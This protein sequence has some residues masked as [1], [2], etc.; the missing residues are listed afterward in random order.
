M[1]DGEAAPR[2]P[3]PGSESRGRTRERRRKARTVL[4]AHPSA[5]LYGSDRVLLESV[6][7]LL[8]AGWQVVATVPRPGPLVDELVAR[9]AGVEICPTPVLRKSALRPAGLVRFALEVAASV[10]PA[11]RLLART[12]AEAV[13]VNTVTVPTWML[14]GR[15][16]R[17]RVLC[18]VHEAEGSASP[19]LRRLLALPLLLAHQVLVNSTFSLDVLGSA[20][21]TLRRRATVI[22]NGVPGPSAPTPARAV[23]TPPIRLLFVGR[24]SPRKGPQVAVAAAAEL[25][26]RGVEV[27]LHLLGA[28]FSGYEWFEAQLRQAVAA[29]GLVDAVRFLGFD[30]DV[31]PHLGASDIVVVPSVL[32]EPFGNTAV[33]A[34]LAARPLV[35]SATSGL[36]EAAQ[37]YPSAVFVTPDQPEALAEAVLDV[38]A[39]WPVYREQALADSARA[40][41]RHSVERYR[42]EVAAVVNRAAKSPSLSLGR[43]RLSRPRSR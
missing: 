13:Y 17:R 32:D 36:R 22:Y 20:I 8:A 33:E 28:V 30:A 18:H 39:N 9:G 11:C 10:A 12:G 41:A 35:V 37:G 25:Q 19:L 3:E 1:S 5:E 29:A 42:S 23:L 2:S 7:G 38:V 31:W 6:S 15:V 40:R 14:W 24:L 34:M 4:V 43:R 21:P 27:H 26:R 16:L